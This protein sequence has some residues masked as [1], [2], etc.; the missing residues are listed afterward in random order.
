MITIEGCLNTGSVKSNSSSVGGIIG[1]VNQ[2]KISLCRNDADSIKGLHTVGGIIGKVVSASGSET[3]DGC[4]N[5]GVVHATGASSGWM[6]VGGLIGWAG[7]YSMINSGNTG[8]ISGTN[9]YA[10]AGLMGD[11]RYSPTIV[12]N[13]FNKSEIYTSYNN[14]AVKMAGLIYSNKCT[15][16]NSTNPVLN[17]YFSG[18]LSCPHASATK[19]AFVLQNSSGYDVY[20]DYIYSPDGMGTT[21]GELK[22]GSYYSKD[23]T[24]HARYHFN[25]N[26][27]YATESNTNTYFS[28][29][30]NLTGALNEWVNSQGEESGYYSWVDSDGDGIPVLVF[31]WPD[32]WN[33]SPSKRQR[34]H[35]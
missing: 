23:A 24:I 8:R 33:S 4:L 20:Y 15:I 2:M 16:G 32:S 6:N 22:S 12:K 17:C 26:G 21:N 7:L 14:S 13:C 27:S 18:T 3:M 9:L 34:A 5:T 31:P 11:V 10:I 19:V 28:S 25:T 29:G 30:K 1:Q 35:K